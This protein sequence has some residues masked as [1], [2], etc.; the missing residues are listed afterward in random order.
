MLLLNYYITKKQGCKNDFIWPI[1]LSNF[2]IVF[3]LLAEIIAI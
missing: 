3:I 2:E 1:G